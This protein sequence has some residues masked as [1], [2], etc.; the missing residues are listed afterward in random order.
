MN[1][2]HLRKTLI[3]GHNNTPRHNCRSF[4]P[5]SGVVVP[6]NPHNPVKMRTVRVRRVLTRT[7]GTEPLRTPTSKHGQRRGEDRCKGQNMQPLSGKTP[8]PKLNNGLVKTTIP[9]RIIQTIIPKWIV[10]HVQVTQNNR[11]P[12]DK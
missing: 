3:A 5:L 10:Q 4:L 6:K 2:K 1:N 9:M 7:P 8:K 12:T 11:S